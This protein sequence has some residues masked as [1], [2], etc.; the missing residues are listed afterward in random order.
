MWSYEKQ[1]ALSIFIVSMIISTTLFVTACGK[2]SDIQD[3]QTEQNEAGI[4]QETNVPR[5]VF[6][7]IDG[8]EFITKSD[9]DPNIS[10][11]WTVLTIS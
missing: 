4:S 11:W 7:M 8:L 2:G 9:V 5:S 1:L 10:D 3:D 6:T